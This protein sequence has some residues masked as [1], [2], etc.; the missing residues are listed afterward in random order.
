MK[1]ASYGS[2]D[3]C[4]KWKGASIRGHHP[5]IPGFLRETGAPSW[6]SMTGLRQWQIIIERDA[7]S[8]PNSLQGQFQTAKYDHDTYDMQPRHGNVT[9]ET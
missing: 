5:A 2:F 8:E 1:T 4:D 7:Q 6:L 9:E 3:R